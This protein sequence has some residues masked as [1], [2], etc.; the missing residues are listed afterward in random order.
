NR[1]VELCMCDMYQA[2]KRHSE[3]YYI[4]IVGGLSLRKCV[5]GSDSWQRRLTTFT[6]LG[7]QIRNPF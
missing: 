6:L 4:G 1:N 5:A 2:L 7:D 3:H